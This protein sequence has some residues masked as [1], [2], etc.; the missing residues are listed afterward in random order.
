ML[1]PLAA[2]FAHL[3]GPKKTNLAAQTPYSARV[4]RLLSRKT[5]ER[6]KIKVC[7]KSEPEPDISGYPKFRVFFFQISFG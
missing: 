5:L 4:V 3:I 1:D 2:Q 7:L 6:K